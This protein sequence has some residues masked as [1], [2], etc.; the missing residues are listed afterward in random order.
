MKIIAQYLCLNYENIMENKLDSMQ[1]FLLFRSPFLSPRSVYVQLWWCGACVSVAG[2]SRGQT[3]PRPRG[4]RSASTGWAPAVGASRPA[5]DSHPCSSV[6][7]TGM[8]W[9]QW[10]CKN[11]KPDSVNH[12]EV[13]LGLTVSK[14][15][16]WLK[17]LPLLTPTQT[18]GYSCS[19]TTSI[20]NTRS[21]QGIGKSMC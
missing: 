13:E 2:T 5:G 3:E 21:G 11:H 4:P 7:T 1:F 15:T 20:S 8:S 6:G 10:V 16:T 12:E 9:P 14:R 19:G 17:S 18:R